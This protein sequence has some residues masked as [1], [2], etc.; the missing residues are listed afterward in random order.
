[1][2]EGRTNIV[3]EYARMQAIFLKYFNI[4]PVIRYFR[5]KQEMNLPTVTLKC[6]LIFFF[7]AGMHS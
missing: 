1:M 6:F 3:P 4:V 5:Y 7:F 2:L